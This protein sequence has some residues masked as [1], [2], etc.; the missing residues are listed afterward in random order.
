MSKILKLSSLLI[1]VLALVALTGCAPKSVDAAKEK[2]QDAGYI[3]V[4]YEGE[5]E[6]LVGAFSAT[7]IISITQAE[8][9]VATLYDSKSSA[10]EA[11]KKASENLK[12]DEVCEQIGK[13]I[14]IGTE[15]AIKDFK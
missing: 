2:M 11:Y 1:M 7:K 9:I 10:K 3:T 6:G 8:S 5:G 4:G 14:V 12:A 13:W 15:Q